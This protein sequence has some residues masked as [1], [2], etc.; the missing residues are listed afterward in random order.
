MVLPQP[1]L[2]LLLLLLSLLPPPVLSR[3]S[4]ETLQPGLPLRISVP[5]DELFTVD[6]ESY[7]R[8]PANLSVDF[9]FDPP[10]VEKGHHL[11]RPIAL[12]H[13]TSASP[14]S[15]NLTA[16]LPPSFSQLPHNSDLFLSPAYIR[17]YN[18]RLLHTGFVSTVRHNNQ[19]VTVYN[20]AAFNNP[21]TFPDAY[22]TLTWLQEQPA[23]AGYFDSAQPASR[24]SP[25]NSRGTCDQ[26]SHCACQLSF[27]AP[28]C[29]ESLSV[30]SKGASNTP[31]NES[32]FEV[33][34]SFLH[35]R[36]VAVVQPLRTVY[37]A[38]NY[39]QLSINQSYTYYFLV[40]ILKGAALPHINDSLQ[41]EL[42]S[43]PQDNSNTMPVW[44][45]DSHAF[46]QLDAAPG[47]PFF[48]ANISFKPSGSRYIV[49]LFANATHASTTASSD[50]YAAF[51]ISAP[52]R[53][54]H[55]IAKPSPIST[56]RFLP[57]AMLPVCLSLIFVAALAV[58]LVFWLDRRSGRRKMVDRLSEA[59]LLRMYPAY[60]AD[61]DEGECPICLGDM[62]R[63]DTLR[64]LRCEHHFHAQCLDPW[65]C[66]TRATCPTCRASVRVEHLS[67][68]RHE[69]VCSRPR[70]CWSLVFCL[71]RDGEAGDGPDGAQSDL[72]DEQ[73]RSLEPQR[74]QIHT[75]GRIVFPD[76]VNWPLPVRT[77][78][79]TPRTRSTAHTSEAGS[80]STSMH[81]ALDLSFSSR[82]HQQ[83]EQAEQRLSSVLDDPAP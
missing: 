8:A 16:L 70:S 23:C 5:G 51:A 63:G 61:D 58:L 60:L 79:S 17:S 48:E 56:Q 50:D 78:S 37:V 76:R 2:P 4:P 77:A 83:R 67:D 74:E 9:A 44:Q 59:E 1:L 15:D 10:V 13:N 7:L 42:A 55:P 69:S 68:N 57:E 24:P 11:P 39:S 43:S 20:V 54:H 82:S 72:Q 45:S 53:I 14:S 28:L 64:A 3:E 33:K 32:D 29:T 62:Q 18:A 75:G 35:D 38:F 25:C 46:K 31:Y 27:T 73:Q 22:L 71:S 40:H 80:E 12:L 47:G 34:P 30:F 36:Y 41:C 52:R 66:G 49:A 81:T 21:S 19:S 26:S 65:V 6:L